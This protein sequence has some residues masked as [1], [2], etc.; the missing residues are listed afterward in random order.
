MRFPTWLR[1]TYLLERYTRGAVPV[2]GIYLSDPPRAAPSC[3][4]RQPLCSLPESGLQG[5]GLPGGT[6]K[7]IYVR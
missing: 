3:G 5:A 7:W 6:H 4:R 1:L 2:D